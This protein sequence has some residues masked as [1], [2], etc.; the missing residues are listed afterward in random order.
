MRPLKLLGQRY[1]QSLL[2]HVKTCLS[3]TLSPVRK[4]AI[5]RSFLTR[6]LGA[7]NESVLNEHCLMDDQ[8]NDA[9]TSNDKERPVVYIVSLVE[10]KNDDGLMRYSRA[11]NE[12]CLD[13][14][15]MNRHLAHLFDVHFDSDISLEELMDTTLITAYLDRMGSR[16][17][18]ND[19]S[20]NVNAHEVAMET[21][22]AAYL[23]GITD[24]LLDHFEIEDLVDEAFFGQ[25]NRG[26]KRIIV[27]IRQALLTQ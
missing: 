21:L 11:S 14:D 10:Y 4:D 27:E 25:L 24:W 23:N 13:I 26:A 20:G 1:D 16:I 22:R 19:E 6:L 17:R 3:E 7:Q 15:A 2:D 18:R 12:V 9:A 8:A 5:A